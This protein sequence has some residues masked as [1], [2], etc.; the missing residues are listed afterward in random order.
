MI[1]V[2]I[3]PAAGAYGQ[4]NADADR[5]RRRHADHG[6]GGYSNQYR[7]VAAERLRNPH[8]AS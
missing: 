5:H 4:P 3:H 1:A 8:V 2:T 7:S 6:G